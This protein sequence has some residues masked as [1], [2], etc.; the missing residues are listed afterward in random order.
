MKELEELEQMLDE[1]LITKTDYQ[2]KKKELEERMKASQE[3]E[4][5]E[6]DVQET[7][8]TEEEVKEP[9]PEPEKIVENPEEDSENDK[10]DK[11]KSKAPIIICIVV[12]AGL[13]LLVGGGLLIAT[14]SF[15]KYKDNIKDADE[16]K[17]VWGNTYY[18]FLK[19]I[20]NDNKQ[21]DAGL[22]DEI[23]DGKLGFYDI[24]GIEDPV[25]VISYEENDETYSNV[26]YIE[27]DK[28]N[29]KVYEDPTDI[30]FLYNIDEEEYDYYLHTADDETDVYQKVS[31]GIKDNT[32]DNYTFSED[33]KKT[34]KDEN[35]ND[36]EISKYDETFIEPEVEDP[37]TDFNYDLDEDELKD[38]VNDSIKDYK[39]KEKLVTDEVEKEV[40][41]HIKEIEDKKEEI[42][43]IEE[44]SYKNGLKN[45]EDALKYELS[46]A[47]GRV[48]YKLFKDGAKTITASALPDYLLTE[49]VYQYLYNKRSDIYDFNKAYTEDEIKEALNDLYGNNY[50]YNHKLKEMGACASLS[51]DDSRNGYVEVGGCGGISFDSDPYYHRVVIEKTNN[52]ITYGYV[53]VVPTADENDMT[54]AKAPY[55]VYKDESKSEEVATFN[56]SP[57]DS[58]LDKV[59][60]DSG[61]K[62][63]IT[64]NIDNGFYHFKEITKLN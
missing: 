8:V 9:D 43:K 29:S 3:T 14:K 28:V 63:K 17:E 30:E 49:A 48:I 38:M 2:K 55:K 47:T 35:G 39:G 40:D 57:S 21:K 37:T 54:I 12:I 62:Y 6:D 5:I 26:Y 25:M 45:M 16:I 33:D 19:D 53:Y 27:D 60:T 59:A 51:W 41:N 44:N 15:D 46:Y 13:V 58:D 50:T 22:P 31:D 23:K 24:E 64:F 7:S 11:K 34:V 20:V 10:A 4:E 36:I 52:T 1:K 18:V 42:K 61:V 32:E 56:S